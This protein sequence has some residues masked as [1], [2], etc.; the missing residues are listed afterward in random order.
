MDPPF[1]LFDSLQRDH[2]LHEVD[3]VSSNRRIDLAVLLQP[4]ASGAPLLM[5]W[6]QRHLR[7]FPSWWK[8]TRQDPA[9]FSM[10]AWRLVD[11]G[12]DVRTAWTW[13]PAE[14]A[15]TTSSFS[16]PILPGKPGARADLLDLL[17]EKGHVGEL[18][19]LERR[20]GAPFSA[21]DLAGR[22]CLNRL[23]GPF[24]SKK[25]EIDVGPAFHRA[26]CGQNLALATWFLDHG[27][28]V[29]LRDGWG[30]TALFEAAQQPAMI[31]LLMA[32]GADP[33]A[34]NDQG[35]SV[36]QHWLDPHRAM[37]RGA[38]SALELA[39]KVPSAV[40]VRDR[41][42]AVRLE[43]HMGLSRGLYPALRTGLRVL[44]PDLGE[45]LL[46][47][48]TAPPTT[49][50]LEEVT[51]AA[52][53][54]VLSSS[55]ENGAWSE[56]LSWLSA[57]TPP[58]GLEAVHD[59]ARWAMLVFNPT[60]QR[61]PSGAAHPEPLR[62]PQ[63]WGA[64]EDVLAEIGADSSRRL[65]VLSALAL[66]ITAALE[67]AVGGPQAPRPA[68]ARVNGWLDPPPSGWLVD[69]GPAGTLLGQAMALLARESTPH[70]AV[71]RLPTPGLAEAL[72]AF[73]ASGRPVPSDTLIPAWRLLMAEP[74]G[75]LPGSRL[76]QRRSPEPGDVADAKNDL[77]QALAWWLTHG[78]T[79]AWDSGVQPQPPPGWDRLQSALLAAPPPW[80]DW[81]AFLEAQRLERSFSPTP[82]APR[83]SKPRL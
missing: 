16:S 81:R 36:A 61:F 83:T 22:T 79:Q 37:F 49:T 41:A 2:P 4:T 50:V 73:V 58:A 80:P 10:L 67:A 53:G 56:V 35:R 64:V 29:N 44:G 76:G 39:A 60:V 55:E 74:L 3:H 23:S 69:H 7:Q 24:F 63:A 8:S 11:A 57:H 82:D 9:F 32:H 62:F 33:H 5:D 38:R 46:G 78:L 59:R 28:D 65:P 30:E 42:K 15:G 25:N 72:M 40:T 31:K 1:T 19:A 75:S 14:N 71:G 17:L 12:V 66:V 18:N 13:A 21:Q 6:W 34:V 47:R 26:V 52:W 48:G 54:T 70:L 45:P 20:W 51:T 68:L 43:A 27:V 77:Q